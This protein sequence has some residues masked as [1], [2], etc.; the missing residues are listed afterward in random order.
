MGRMQTEAASLGAEGIVGVRYEL[1]TRLSLSD[2]EF[3]ER[4][5]DQ[6]H[7]GPPANQWRSFVADIFAVGTSIAPLDAEHEIPKASLVLPLDG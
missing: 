1:S 2:E 3:R 7:N 5:N 6:G 4:I